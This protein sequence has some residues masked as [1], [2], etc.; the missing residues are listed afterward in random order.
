MKYINRVAYGFH[1]Y[2]WNNIELKQ[3]LDKYN[4]IVGY[5]NDLSLFD[6]NYI[7]IYFK[8]TY[9]NIK[10][11]VL[12]IHQILDDKPCPKLTDIELQVLQLFN[13]HIYQKCVWIH[14]G[15]FFDI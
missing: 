15:E 3:L 6:K 14:H 4:D 5:D 7:F 12:Y 11:P 2:S 13:T 10:N 9:Q 8:S 1:A